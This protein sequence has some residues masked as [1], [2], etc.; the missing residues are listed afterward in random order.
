MIDH[1][2]PRKSS[3]LAMTNT[4][5]GRARGEDKDEGNSNVGNS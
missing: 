3:W 2:V 4:S 1:V 5:Q